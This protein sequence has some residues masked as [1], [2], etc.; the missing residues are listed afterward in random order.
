VWII[1]SSSTTKTPLGCAEERSMAILQP[2]RWHPTLV[3]GFLRAT[4]SAYLRRP[5]RL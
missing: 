3:V 4:S 2:L 1:T 5:S